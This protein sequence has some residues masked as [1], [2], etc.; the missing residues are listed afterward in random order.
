MTATALGALHPAWRRFRPMRLAWG[1]GRAA[2]SLSGTLIDAST[3][4]A[5]ITIRIF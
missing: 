5:T 1:L 3:P 2:A 4:R